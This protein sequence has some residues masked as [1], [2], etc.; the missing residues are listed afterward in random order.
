MADNKIE[1]GDK[2][3]CASSSHLAT[4]VRISFS[5][6]EPSARNSDARLLSSAQQRGIHCD[7]PQ[8]HSHPEHIANA[9]SSP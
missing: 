4:L 2:G 1:E 3:K 7:T 5:T 9:I 8:P 6:T